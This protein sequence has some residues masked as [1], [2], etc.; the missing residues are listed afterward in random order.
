M[1]RNKMNE[2][3]KI[4]SKHNNDNP[5]DKVFIK[6]ILG[7][8]TIVKQSAY[9]INNNLT[10]LNSNDNSVSDHTSTQKNL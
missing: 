4:V 1:Q 8:P 7:K 9:A 10:N 2:L 5:N 6:Y 3:N